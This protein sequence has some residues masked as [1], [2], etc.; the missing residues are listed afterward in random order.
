MDTKQ[1]HRLSPEYVLLGFLHQ[2]PSHGY[3]LHRRL[4]DEFGFIWHV[5]QSQTYNILKRLECQGSITST[6]VEQEKLPSR[7][8]LYLTD[9]GYH[10][11][12]TWL[13][14]PTSCSVHAIRVEFITRL[15]F[16]K[17]Y[18]PQKIQDIIRSQSTEVRKGLYRLEGMRSSIPAIQT[19]NR[20][21][22][23][24][25][26]KLLTSIISWLEECDDVFAHNH[27]QGD[28]GA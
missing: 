13:D 12:N 25:R 16:I 18:Q 17:Q 27:S 10:R 26:I 15:Y 1:S 4:L 24:M 23:D 7:Q 5:S 21:A 11:F 6:T 19:F 14:T 22:L 28:E 8:L 20:L 3:E 9:V 2:N